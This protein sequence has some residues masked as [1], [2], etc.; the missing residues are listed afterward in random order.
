MMGREQH[1]FQCGLLLGAALMAHQQREELAEI[2]E[3]LRRVEH[4]RP[5]PPRA[6]PRLVFAGWRHGQRLYRIV[7]RCCG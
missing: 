4:L 7:G 6:L 1:A 2:D 3:R 5:P